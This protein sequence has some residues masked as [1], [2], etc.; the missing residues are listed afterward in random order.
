[1][2]VSGSC[3]YIKQMSVLVNC[4]LPFYPF[5]CSMLFNVLR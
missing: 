1:M 5:D 3:L 4:N 2:Y